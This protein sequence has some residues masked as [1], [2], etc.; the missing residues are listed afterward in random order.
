MIVRV[1]V[2]SPV[3]C[4]LAAVLFRIFHDAH[5]TAEHFRSFVVQV[6]LMRFLLPYPTKFTRLIPA[7]GSPF[8]KP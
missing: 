5:F 8:L 6:L 2:T 7:D 3:P 1:L 4:V